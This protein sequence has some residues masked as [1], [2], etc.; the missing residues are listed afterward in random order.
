M[1]CGCSTPTQASNWTPVPSVDNPAEIQAGENVECFSTRANNVEKTA[2]EAIEN[3]IENTAIVSDLELAV[4]TTFRLT[5]NSTKT[6]YTWR[7]W[8]NGAPDVPSGMGL[9]FNTSTGLLSGTVVSS[10]ANKNYEVEVKAFETA[11]SETANE[12]IDSRK[13]NFFPKS[14]TTENKGDVIK[15]IYPMTNEKRKPVITSL[16]GPRKPPKQGASGN[17][18][19]I[20]IASGGQGK[21]LAAADGEVI[22]AGPASGFGNWIRIS[23]KNAAGKQLAVT[24]YGH[25][26]DL[27]VKVGQKVSAG[28]VIA[29]E[30]NAGIGTGPHLHFEL[31]LGS[32]KMGA[33]VD[34]MPYI[35]GTYTAARNNSAGDSSKADPA[36]L[37]TI[38]TTNSGITKSQAENRPKCPSVGAITTPD[39]TNT[40]VTT[41]PPAAPSSTVPPTT[42]PSKAAVRSEIERAL[43]EDPALDAADKNFLIF[44]AKIES[45]FNAKAHN[46]KSNAKGVFQM[47]PHIADH[48]FKKIGKPS[49]DE[50]IF[51]PYTAT[52]AMIVM[53]KNG[54][55]RYWQMWL[56]SGKTKI[57][58]MPVVAN[59]VTAEY[60]S[61]NQGEFM[62]GIVHNNGV[63]NSARGINVEGGIAYYRRKVNEVS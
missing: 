51:D 15:L 19:G 27:Y 45:G 11:G 47:L 40:P 62:Y 37:E 7:I 60:A 4:N 10:F 14:A 13:F 36:T 35:N 17:H 16:W 9:T 1:S 5:V 31:H 33:G 52:K 25:M 26:F 54:H 2:G 63:G 46:K 12:F 18:P 6:V 30:G 23:H 22:S 34:P 49:T 58:G 44:V 48:F 39:N 29:K 53:Y 57:A 24:V 28:Q 43:N 56:D 3:K 55:K 20:D 32:W 61:L 38:T 21:I 8:F 59:A 50:N 41:Y 42:D